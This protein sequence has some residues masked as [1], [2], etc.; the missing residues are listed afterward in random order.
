MLDLLLLATLAAAPQPADTVVELRRGDRV[1][2]ENFSG[3]IAVSGWGDDRLEVRGEERE[4]AVG[5]RREGSVVRVVRAEARRGGRSVEMTLRV[6]R[7]VELQ[8][9]GPSLD[10]SVEGI[11]GPVRIGNVSGDIRVRDIGGALDVRSIDGE[12]L[13]DDARGGVRASS[14]SEDVTVRGV[15]G[16]VEVHSG[17]GDIMLADVR[18]A[19]VRAETQDGDI[20]FSGEVSAGGE[21]G[22]FL[23]DGDARIA[24]PSTTGARVRVSTFDGEF[25]SEFPVVVERFSSGR[26]FEFVLGDGSA[27]F[28]I[29]VFDGEIRLL[30]RR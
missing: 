14:Q 8:I 3:E 28:Q 12:I 30:Q 1:V 25:A 26:E 17:S 20:D 11:D 18:S 6:P 9:G 23:H 21:Y 15:T 4:E 7:W 27:H 29:E 2:L 10:V 24:I 19:S 13:V 5:V 16:P 22:F